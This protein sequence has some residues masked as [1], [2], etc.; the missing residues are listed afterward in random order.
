MTFLVRRSGAGF[1]LCLFFSSVVLTAGPCNRTVLFAWPQSVPLPSLFFFA[2]VDL[3]DAL[4]WLA[5]NNLRGKAPSKEKS[6]RR[7]RSAPSFFCCANGQKSWRPENFGWPLD[8]A[9]AAAQDIRQGDVRRGKKREIPW[10]AFKKITDIKREK[11][12]Q[13]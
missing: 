2:K 3:H 13:T 10:P 5:P 6:T 11:E 1:F 9:A 7:R 4:F 12:M 8:M